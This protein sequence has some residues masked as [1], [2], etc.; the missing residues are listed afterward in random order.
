MVQVTNEYP[1]KLEEAFR[2]LKR[3]RHI[4]RDDIRVYRDLKQHQ[5]TYEQL[6]RALGFELIYHSRDFFYFEGSNHYRTKRLEQAT[7]FVLILFQDLEDKKL[8]TQQRQWQKTLLNRHFKISELPHFATTKRRQVM[9]DA[10]IRK[11]TLQK[12]VLDTLKKIGMLEMVGP[13]QFLFRSPI[14]RMIDLCVEF[15]EREDMTPSDAADSETSTDDLTA[16]GNTS[17]SQ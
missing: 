2:L 3:G 14:F 13:N 5:E 10:G 4:C 11:E 16:T 6:F 1:P 7:L 17:E 8:Q 12:Q 9:S 15:A